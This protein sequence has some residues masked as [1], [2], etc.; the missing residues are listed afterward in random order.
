MNGSDPSGLCVSATAALATELVWLWEIP[1]FAGI[2]PPP[3]FV[4]PQ[5]NRFDAGC[6]K[7]ARN[8][9][10]RRQ[11]RR[12]HSTPNA[13]CDSLDGGKTVK[14]YGP[15]YRLVSKDGYSDNCVKTE[16]TVLW[17][18]LY[19]VNSYKNGAGASLL[20]NFTNNSW[21]PNTASSSCT[22][23]VGFQQFICEVGSVMKYNPA[24]LSDLGCAQLFGQINEQSLA[25]FAYMFNSPLLS[26]GQ[27][28]LNIYQDLM[29]KTPTLA[30]G[31][32][33]F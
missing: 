19:S 28:A 20:T 4:K 7:M 6:R 24:C 13:F 33:F 29:D 16:L 22:A 30:S 10:L 21:G 14:V 15:F 17:L 11:N 9:G 5:A 8:S 26:I 23:G 32:G 1:A 3:N 25:W 2:Y 18:G 31:S 27:T 12:W